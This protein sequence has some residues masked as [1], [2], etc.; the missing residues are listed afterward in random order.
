MGYFTG[1][2]QY[3]GEKFNQFPATAGRLRI[4]TSLLL[5]STRTVQNL[6]TRS[7]Y[8]AFYQAET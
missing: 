5:L 8:P 6:C 2:Y 3:S 4:L 7:I 1:A